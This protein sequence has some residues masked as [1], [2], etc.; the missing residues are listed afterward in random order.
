MRII[1]AIEWTIHDAV[2]ELI[3]HTPT[4]TEQIRFNDGAG[5][6]HYMGEWSRLAGAAFLE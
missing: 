3:P 6:D 4:M 1:D 2:L 5:Y